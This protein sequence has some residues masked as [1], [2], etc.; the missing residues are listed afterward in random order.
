MK[1]QSSN[2][3]IRFEKDVAWAETGDRYLLKLFRDYLFHQ[4][5]EKNEPVIDLAHVIACLN[6]V[7]F[8]DSQLDVG[9]DERI[10]LMSRDEQS[11]LIV[12]YRELKQCVDTT[13]KEL[14]SKSAILQ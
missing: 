3:L 9:V 10:M 6:K 4:V 11:C 1:G 2:S 14:V 13:F 5:S 12:S 8:T 7:Y